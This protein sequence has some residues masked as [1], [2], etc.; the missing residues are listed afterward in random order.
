MKFI[1]IHVGKTT[2][3]YL[4]EGISIYL[5]RL[6]HYVPVTEV[7]VQPSK[8]KDRSK[9]LAEEERAIVQKI[10][11]GDLLVV[12]DEKGK[13]ISSVQLAGTIEKWMV[14]GKGRIV[15]ITGGAFGISHDLKNKANMILSLSKLTFTHQMVRLILTEQLYRAMTITRNEGYHHE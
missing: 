6:Q 9:S 12:L 3:D 10:S 8:E 5:K 7:I 4:K 15:F 14:Q 11:P 1:L 13:E 2:E